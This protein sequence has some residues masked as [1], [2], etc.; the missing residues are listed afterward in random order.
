[1][2]L[3]ILFAIL[4]TQTFAILISPTYAE[5]THV[6]AGIAYVIFT[7]AVWICAYTAQEKYNGYED[8][9]AELKKEIKNLKKNME[10]K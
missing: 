9:I 3:A 1:M 8:K 7:T 6:I 5:T 10:E 2:Y 4:A